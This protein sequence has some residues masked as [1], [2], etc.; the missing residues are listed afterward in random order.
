ME[1]EVQKHILAEVLDGCLAPAV[2]KIL[3][4]CHAGPE[5]PLTAYFADMR[6]DMLKN[7]EA[8]IPHEVQQPLDPRAMTQASEDTLSHYE[9]NCFVDNQP[10]AGAPVIVEECDSFVGVASLTFTFGSVTVKVEPFPRVDAI[11][12]SPFIV[13]A[14]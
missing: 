8:F 1:L 7:L 13:A 9:I 12:I 5:H 2:K 4:L 11:V 6:E 10:G 14:S 3:K